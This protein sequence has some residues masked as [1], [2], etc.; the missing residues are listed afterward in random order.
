[1]PWD[2]CEQDMVHK[3]FVLWRQVGN[4]LLRTSVF[5]TPRLKYEYF[6]WDIEHDSRDMLAMVQKVSVISF[7]GAE[8][9]GI[10]HEKEEK[11]WLVHAYIFPT[12]ASILFYLILMQF[13]GTGNQ[14]C[15]ESLA[16]CLMIE[17]SGTVWNINKNHNDRSWNINPKKGNIWWWSNCY[18][19]SQGLKEWMTKKNYERN[20]ESSDS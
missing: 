17:M 10:L 4:Y 3:R 16:S 6:S 7:L 11:W 8:L 9:Q 1:M 14:W 15:T 5:F 13:L 2:N 19:Q 20:Y 18:E 12:S